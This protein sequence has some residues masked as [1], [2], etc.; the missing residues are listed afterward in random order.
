M[1]ETGMTPTRRRTR[2]VA[3]LGLTAVLG[4]SM[5][6]GLV[7]VAGPASAATW[8]DPPAP[9]AAAG[10]SVGAVIGG[11][12]VP[13]RS[14]VVR[15]TVTDDHREFLDI[16]YAAAPVGALR[17]APPAPPA[18]WTGVRDATTQGQQCPQNANE[19]E[20]AGWSDD[21]LDLNVWTPPNHPHARNLP[22]VM[23]IHGG[24]HDHSSGRIFDA[25]RMAQQGNAVV[26][27]INYRL[28]VFG[29]LA[30]GALNG[31]SSPGS[32]A[33]GLMDQ[34]AALQWIHSN[35]AAFG[36]DA[37]HVMIAGQSSGAADVCSL[38]AS[39]PAAGLF[40]SAVIESASCSS[41]SQSYGLSQGASFAKKVGCTDAAT[42]VGCLQSKPTADI[43]A[44]EAHTSWGP[45]VGSSYLPV[46]P[47]DAF[48]SGTFNHVPV[49]KGATHDEAR[50]TLRFQRLSS[51]GYNSRITSTYRT[52][53]QAVL[54]AYPVDAYSSPLLAYATVQSDQSACATR[55]LD[56]TMSQSL[57]LYT[58]E[59]DDPNAP[60]YPGVVNPNLPLGPTHT[61]ELAYLF[62]LNGQPAPFDAAQQ[63]LAAQMIQYWTTFAR[64]GNPNP[65]GLPAMPHYST[66]TDQFLSLRP[67]GNEVITNYATDH[68][69]T[70]WDRIG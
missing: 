55:R 31:T 65:Q 18:R 49:I 70:L 23:W 13:T 40:S 50:F 39:P 58:Y 62:D 10:G 16:P 4:L 11:A 26:V 5:L 28:G 57:Q 51:A 67:P 3:A 56:A 69:C 7:A 21:C 1:S 12:F 41:H 9:A 53:A 25:T 19:L 63:Q 66:A 32:G 48:A 43:V 22:V 14:G 33:Y 60:N 45:S 44:A 35:I 61:S 27:T 42:V 38:L 8:G 37:R 54:D 52:N 47:L 30:L 29:N 64:T 17:W 6:S 20:A 15:G 59:F 68:H 2:H 36:G 46:A 24:A 34:V